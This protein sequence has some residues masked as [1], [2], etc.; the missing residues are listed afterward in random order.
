MF[1]LETSSDVSAGKRVLL[2]RGAL[3]F[4]KAVQ[5]RRECP[6]AENGLA[7]QD[8]VVIAAQEILRV[9][10]VSLDSLYANDKRGQTAHQD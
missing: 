5:T 9:L 1:L 10:E 8:L 2:C 7:L 4:E 3:F 6:E